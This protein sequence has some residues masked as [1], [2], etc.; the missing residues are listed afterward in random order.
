[1]SI[2]KRK[3]LHKAEGLVNTNDTIIGL[4][5]ALA[6]QEKIVSSYVV[7]NSEQEKMILLLKPIYVLA[8]R[9][10]ICEHDHSF[11]LSQGGIKTVRKELHEAISKSENT[12]LII[13]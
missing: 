6:Q 2:K 9:Y 5:K 13:D 12:R 8:R 3:K 1:M 4:R 10:L 7:H 11:A